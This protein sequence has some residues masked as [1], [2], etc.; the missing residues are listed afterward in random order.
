MAATLVVGA[1]SAATSA[2][3]YQKK[4]VQENSKNGDT[5]TIQK[6]EQ[7]GTVSGFD[8]TAEQECAN[9]ICTHPGNNAT[10]TQEG[11]ATPP[12]PVKLTC[13]QC[14]MKFLSTKQLASLGSGLL[15]ELPE[16]CAKLDSG[17]LSLDK[18]TDALNAVEKATGE[19]IDQAGLIQCLRDA[20]IHLSTA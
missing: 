4:G 15:I 1:T 13:E 3:A 20:G 9:L 14:F 5:V 11:A 17:A 2:F 7:D 18:L 12:T 6:C 10:C 19:P 8:N 16:L